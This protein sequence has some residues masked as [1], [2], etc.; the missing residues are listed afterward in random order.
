M[1]SATA[2]G[3]LSSEEKSVQPNQSMWPVQDKHAVMVDHT[4]F[5][6]GMLDYWIFAC[7]HLGLGVNQ[8]W[9]AISPPKNKYLSI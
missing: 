2:P 8:N 6:F 9:L 7:I 1:V 3:S 5:D 4:A